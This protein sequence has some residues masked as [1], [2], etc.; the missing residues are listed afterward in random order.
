M[1]KFNINLSIIHAYLCGDG[2]VVKNPTTQK[3]KYYYI[4]F[5]NTNKILLDDFENN[6]YNYSR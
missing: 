3:K 2:Y 4:G 1:L 6:F 5:R